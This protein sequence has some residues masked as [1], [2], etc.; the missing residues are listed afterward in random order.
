MSGISDAQQDSAANSAPWPPSSPRV[1]HAQPED[2][3]TI[4]RRY[5]RSQSIR[6]AEGLT[7]AA[8]NSGAG[9]NKSAS[10]MAQDLVDAAQIIED[11]LLHNSLAD[12][13]G[14]ALSRASDAVLSSLT[15]AW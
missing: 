3:E 4:H 14:Q 7:H 12:Q 6:I 13:S 8:A 11:A 2:P 10:D 5:A 9:S 1:G 15:G